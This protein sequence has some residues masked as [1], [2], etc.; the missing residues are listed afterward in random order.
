MV[1]AAGIPGDYSQAP[2]DAFDGDDWNKVLGTNLFGT[3]YM[4]KYG[5]PECS[6]GGVGSIIAL[7]SLAS[8]KVAG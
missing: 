7:M 6:K 8:F 3:Y 1:L 4:T 5:W 2:E